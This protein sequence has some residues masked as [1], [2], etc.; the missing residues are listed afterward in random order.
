MTG[1]W[2]DLPKIPRGLRHCAGLSIR[3]FQS[4][5]DNREPTI[6]QLEFVRM[7]SNSPKLAASTDSDVAVANAWAGFFARRNGALAAGDRQPATGPSK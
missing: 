5:A 2:T 3:D 6:P 7:A 4:Y 1:R